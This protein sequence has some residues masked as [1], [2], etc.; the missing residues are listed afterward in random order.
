M[1]SYTKLRDGSWGVRTEGRVVEGLVVTVTK[2]DGSV[3]TETIGRVLW[4]GADQTTGRT[5]SLCSIVPYDRPPSSPR[6][7]A[8]AWSRP[9]TSRKGRCRNPRDCGDP[10]CQGEC[11]YE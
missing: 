10:T 3:K 1:A 9:S 8:S 11:G 5:V 7:M 4:T 2:R 6:P